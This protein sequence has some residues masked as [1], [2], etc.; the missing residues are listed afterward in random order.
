[1][2]PR[3]FWVESAPK[4]IKKLVPNRKIGSMQHVTEYYKQV[5]IVKEYEIEE[6]DESQINQYYENLEHS[7]IS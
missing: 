5:Q 1:M 3:K 7:V 2:H 6:E 4:V